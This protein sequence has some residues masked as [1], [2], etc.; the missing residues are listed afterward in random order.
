MNPLRQHFDKLLLLLGLIALALSVVF[1]LQ[2]LSSSP[3]SHFTIREKGSSPE[4]LPIVQLEELSTTY[5]RPYQLVTSNMLAF[6][7]EFRVAC[8]NQNH[9]LLRPDTEV[10][11]YCN[12]TQPR[13]DPN[14]DTDEDGLPD[15]WE[16]AHGT[17]RAVADDFLDL[18]GDGFT[19]MEEYLAGTHPN[20]DT[21]HPPLYLKLRVFGTL[22]KPLKF[23]LLSISKVGETHRF[24]VAMPERT[25]FLTLGQEVEGWIAEAFDQDAQVLTI[26]A[27]GETM[28][29]PRWQEVALNQRIARI[30]SLAK[31]DF[32][33]DVTIGAS[34]VVQGQTWKVIRIGDNEVEIEG[35]PLAEGDAPLLRT[36]QKVTPEETLAAQRAKSAPADGRPMLNENFPGSPLEYQRRNPGSQEQGDGAFFR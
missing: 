23:K 12:A 10:C 29:L 1:I 15:S 28:K 24:Q 14:A 33:E 25:H 32:K 8:T 22:N 4:I 36:L 6:V 31:S 17:D 27:G 11:P 20:D 7:S 19:N 16:L 34:F 9:V 3:E 30:I 35:S 5:S 26:R 2:G 18:D 21:S 13:K